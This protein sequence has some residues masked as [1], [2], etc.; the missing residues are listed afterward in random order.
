MS[1]HFTVRSHAG[2]ERAPQMAKIRTNWVAFNNLQPLDQVQGL[3]K[4]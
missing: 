2:S 3:R 1:T 4:V